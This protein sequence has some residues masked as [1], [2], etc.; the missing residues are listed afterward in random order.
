MNP[1]ALPPM[2]PS[3]LWDVNDVLDNPGTIERLCEQSDAEIARS[4]EQASQVC[5]WVRT[6][7]RCFGLRIVEAVQDYS[8]IFSSTRFRDLIRVKVC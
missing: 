2:Y 1:E 4:L 6:F 5:V 3:P 8:G 7:M